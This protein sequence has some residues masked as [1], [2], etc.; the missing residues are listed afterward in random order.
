MQSNSN[1]K[2][3]KKKLYIKNNLSPY[4]LNTAKIDLFLDCKRCFYLDVKKGIRRTN[5]APLVL[6]N[7][8]NQIVKSEFNKYRKSETSN[9]IMTEFSVDLI[10]ANQ[11][12]LES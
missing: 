11:S 3:C 7:I 4:P 9:S 12:K 8:I 10:P 5:G 1:K 2:K 6:N